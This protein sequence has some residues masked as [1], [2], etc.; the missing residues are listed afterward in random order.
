MKGIWRYYNQM[1]NPNLH[2][3]GNWAQEEALVNAVE[4]HS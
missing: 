1:D 4:A 2:F 3:A